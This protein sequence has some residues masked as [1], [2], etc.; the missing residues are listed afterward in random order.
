MEAPVIGIIRGEVGIPEES[1]QRAA[2][3]PKNPK[4][5]P[6]TLD[7]TIVVNKGNKEP[8]TPETNPGTL[9][10]TIVINTGDEELKNPEN[11]LTAP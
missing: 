3:T 5:N 4:T 7:D 11:T 2:P 9:D 10:D 8:K 6:G 1:I